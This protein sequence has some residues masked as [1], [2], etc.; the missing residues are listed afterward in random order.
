MRDN[1]HVPK[2]A[3]VITRSA[4]NK[5]AAYDN[6]PKEV[7]DV[8]KYLPLDITTIGEPFSASIELSD[9]SLFLREHAGIPTAMTFKLMKENGV[10]VQKP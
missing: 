7:R 2:G 8:F 3:P 9:A 6:M 5:M 4:Q 1:V 10:Q